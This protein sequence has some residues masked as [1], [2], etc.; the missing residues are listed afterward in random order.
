MGDEQGRQPIGIV[1]TVLGVVVL[2]FC[3]DA[4]EGPIRAYLLDVADT[5]DQDMA[6]NIH[7]A[8][9]GIAETRYVHTHNFC[10]MFVLKCWIYCREIYWSA[11]HKLALKEKIR[12]GTNHFCLL[13]FCKGELFR[14]FICAGLGGAVGYALGGLDW[15]HTFLGAA[16]KSQ[17]QILFFFAAILFS[18]SVVLHLLSIEE[19][20]YSSQHER[21]DQ[22]LCVVQH[23]ALLFLFT[24]F[25]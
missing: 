14:L 10:R 2:D 21:L 22:V 11:W 3:A 25:F 24:Y 12:P 4:T 18:V 23:L 7:A 6:L 9:A 13:L 5:E 15:T 1:L 20:Q 16:F 19:V 8:S 17:E